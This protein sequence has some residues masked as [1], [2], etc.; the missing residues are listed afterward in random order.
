MT[1]EFKDIIEKLR[2]LDNHERYLWLLNEYPLESKDYYLAFQIIP[3]FSWGRKERKLLMEYYLSKL[4]FASER[5]YLVFLK[6]SPLKEFLDVLDKIVD[7]KINND[8]SLLS[9]HLDRIFK[10][11][12]N[13]N[14]YEN[15]KLY[16]QEIMQKIEKNISGK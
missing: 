13:E 5:P 2:K 4:P 15:N 10:Y 12:V 14:D 9:Y 16:L 8:L 7:R 11:E 3:L 6:I 1:N